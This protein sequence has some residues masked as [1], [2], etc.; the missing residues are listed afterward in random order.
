MP[1]WIP[2]AGPMSVP[3]RIGTGWYCCVDTRHDISIRTSDL[4]RKKKEKRKEQ[5]VVEEVEEKEGR[6]K[7]RW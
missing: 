1:F 6:R 5:I 3:D 2:N 4:K 7:R